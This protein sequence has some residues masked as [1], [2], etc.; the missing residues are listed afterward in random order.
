[1]RIID[2]HDVKLL[3]NFCVN[4]QLFF[5]EWRNNLL[6]QVYRDDIVQNI[7]ALNFFVSLFNIC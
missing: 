7:Q 6:A 1:M 5:F 2:L 3:D 4:F